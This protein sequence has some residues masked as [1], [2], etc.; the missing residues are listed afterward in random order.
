M[1]TLLQTVEDMW[2]VSTDNQKTG[3]I[4]TQYV[5]RTREQTLT[6]CDGCSLAPNADGGCYA[7]SGKVSRGA[8]SVRR[9]TDRGRPA[10]LGAALDRTPR[11]AKC[12]RF[13]AIGDPARVARCKTNA[14]ISYARSEGFRVLGYTHHW[15]SEPHNGRLK[16]SFLASCETMA[17]AREAL[18]RG[19]LVSVAGPESVPGMVTCPNYAKPEVQCN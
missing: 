12:V 9:A 6:S 19:W 11:S 3:D 8:G 17:Q 13:G 14:D 5:G 16:E 18:A 10:D 1:P 15:K 4:P 2:T 7:W